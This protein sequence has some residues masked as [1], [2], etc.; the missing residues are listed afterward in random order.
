MFVV[1]GFQSNR[2][3]AANAQSEYEKCRQRWSHVYSHESCL[4]SWVMFV[5]QVPILNM[6]SAVNVGHMFV[7]TSAGGRLPSHE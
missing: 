7:A 6:G 5:K 1:T 3:S 4:W 2:K